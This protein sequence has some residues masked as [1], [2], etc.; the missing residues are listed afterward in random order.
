[1]QQRALADLT[2][3]AIGLGG[4]PMS[5]EGRPDTERVGGHDPRRARR[6]GHPHRHRR[7]LPPARRRGRPQRGAHRR[8]PCARGAATRRRCSSRPRAGTCARATARGPSTA[9]RRTSSRRPATRPGG[10]ASTRSASTSSTAPTRRCPTP[11]RSGRCVELLDEG[12]IVRAGI[13]NA[14]VAQIDEAQRGARR[15]A[16]V[17]AEPVLAD[18]PLQPRRARALRRARHRVPAVE[19]ARRHLERRRAR[20]E[21]RRVRRGGRGARGEPAAGGPGLGAVAGRRRHPDPGGVAAGVDRGLGA[22]GR[23]APHRR[24]AGPPQRDA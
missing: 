13:S 23:P 20:R 12:V 1:M 18:V 11:S 3:S 21:P 4:M 22:R 2:V 8:A 19:P 17:G 7:R 14:T 5:I 6:R 24:R 15:P 9:T 16:G 10:S